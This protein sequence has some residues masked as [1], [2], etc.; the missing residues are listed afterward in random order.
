MRLKQKGTEVNALNIAITP[1]IQRGT[2]FNK[3]ICHQGTAS[4][5]WM[6][7]AQGKDKTEIMY[8]IRKRTVS[9]WPDN[10]T[11]VLLSYFYYATD[12]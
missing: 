4:H 2:R 5:V 10:I 12:Y 9:R 7:W 3:S 1:H 11:T 8:E 6:K